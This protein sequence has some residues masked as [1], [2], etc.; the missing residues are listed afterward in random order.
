M[1][2]LV[3]P[4][5]PSDEIL[6]DPDI[7]PDQMFLSLQDLSL[8]HRWWGSARALERFLVGEIRRQ[9]VE[10]PVVLDVGAGS[11]DVSRRIS[12]S[13]ARAGHPA[14]VVAC[15]LQW[16]HLLAGRSLARDAF[17]SVCADAFVLPFAEK[18]VDFVVSTLFFHHFSPD[19]NGRLLASFERVARRGFALLD[20]TRHLFPL[21]FISV[22]GRLVFKT[23]ISVCDGISSVRQAYTPDEARRIAQGAVSVARVERIFPF[24]YILSATP[25]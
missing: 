23:R 18:S 4:R 7:P 2:L 24:R 9:E 10:R 25:P 11:A 19:E 5:R 6:D 20:L 15:D 16:R 12:H 22:A 3:P 17:P 21:A 1:S 13:L 14:K 8:V